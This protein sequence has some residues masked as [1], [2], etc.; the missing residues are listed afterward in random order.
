ME[1]STKR[2]IYYDYT[3]TMVFGGQSHNIKSMGN[4]KNM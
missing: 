3:T 2:L 4:A 1:K